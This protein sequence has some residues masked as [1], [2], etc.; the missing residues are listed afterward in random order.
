MNK[1]C[2]AYLQI[3]LLVSFS[4]SLSYLIHQTDISAN[5][6]YEIE[7]Y[8]LEKDVGKIL[9]F[10]GRILFSKVFVSALEEQDLLDGPA[11]CLLTKEGAYCQQYPSSEC[12]ELCTSAC[13]QAPL[14][15]VNECH[16]TC[17]D[18]N[19]GSCAPN[20]PRISCTTGQWFNS[21]VENVQQCKIGC[22]VLGSRARLMTQQQC[23]YTLSALGRQ[24]NYRPDV[25]TVESCNALA[26]SI[27]EGACVIELNEEKRCKFT[28]KSDCDNVI[29]GD[30]YEGTL[31]SNP[32]LNTTCERQKTTGCVQ[33]KDEV[34]WLDSC[35][36]RENIY[37]RDKARSF[38][39]GFV[40]AKSE[41]CQLGTSLNPFSNKARCGNCD[42][43][44]GSICGRAS[45]PGE[46]AFGSYVCK[47]LGC[48]DENGKRREHLESW[49]QYQGSIGVD[50]SKNRATDTPG[51][52]HFRNTCVRGEIEQ[53]ACADFRNEICVESKTNIGGGRQF[54]TAACR[55]NQWQSCV[56]YNTESDEG[57]RLSQCNANPDCFVKKVNV[58]S[59]FRFDLC[60][61]KYPPGFNLE[62]NGR[63]EGA[64]LLCS[65]ASLSCTKIM[66]KKI[67]GWK[68]KANC[69]CDSAQFTQQV[70]DLC[71]SLGDCGAS[72]NYLGMNG[73]GYRVSGA[74]G[75]SAG[76][77]A[78]LSS[79]SN[80]VPGKVASPG[81]IGY[82]TG[83]LGIPPGV[84]SAE[85]ADSV[86]GILGGAQQASLLLALPDLAIGGAIYIG[87]LQASAVSPGV[88]AGAGALV[89][90]S[91]GL[92]VT[93]LLIDKLG[94]GPGLSSGVI[95]TLL[96]AGAIGGALVGYAVSSQILLAG[97]VI[98]SALPGAAALGPV[99]WII[100]A[101][102]LIAIALL[103]IF[104]IGKV[105]K[106]QVSFQC[107][108]WQPPLGGSQ[109]D[110]CGSDGLPCSKYA[111]QSLGQTCTIINENTE[112]ASCID[113]SPD[114]VAS[115]TIKPLEGVITD[116]H[117]YTNIQD[118]GFNIEGPG[119][120]V[121]A[122]TNLIFG[123]SLD[124][125][126]QCAADI[127]PTLSY[128]EMELQLG[129]SSLFRKNHTV[130]LPVPSLAELGLEEYDPGTNGSY[131]L[132]VR[133][134]DKKGNV[135][136]QE[137]KINFCIGKGIDVTP[138][139][140]T[141]RIPPQDTVSWNATSQF[142][143]I[144]VNE[145]A[146]CH[147]DVANKVYEQ[148]ANNL[149]CYTD[150][151]DREPF[152]WRCEDTFPVG[153]ST[154]NFYVRC[155]DQPWLMNDTV[156]SDI[157]FNSTD[158]KTYQ[159]NSNSESYTFS[160]QRSS[161]PLIISSISPNS[162]I[163]FGATP[164]AIALDVRT[165]GGVDGKADCSYKLNRNGEPIGGD[166]FVPP[167][168]QIHQANL[169][170]IEGQYELDISCK[171]KAEN[172]AEKRARFEVL[173]DTKA[174]M[175]TRV[176]KNGG[177]FRVITDE[178]ATCA[179]LLENE[180]VNVF[181]N[182]TDL[183]GAGSRIHELAFEHDTTYFIGCKDQF[184]NNQGSLCSAIIKSG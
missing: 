92:A 168:R 86:S 75:L 25:T 40:L 22:C 16:G 47:D 88:A 73:D 83:L 155:K 69:E 48:V 170:L 177:M 166:S 134:R 107:N 144:Y 181:S 59:N 84:G 118:N 128:D 79:Y 37:D 165:S 46:A 104:G 82:Y 116:L 31:C 129:A 137:Y 35:G 5:A 77:L 146:E 110:K 93:G 95:Y 123:V 171:D 150:L 131:N 28:T 50:E 56:Y 64:E 72:V 108:P 91:I 172:S 54:S 178:S 68:C 101:V 7:D 163:E 9:E 175:V 125:P 43:T 99:G 80:V 87:A 145:P 94:I 140:I 147:W 138:P 41:S 39:N 21:P 71:M 63:G 132:F 98:Q 109:C 162:T 167:D 19:Y 97:G 133:C 157:P 153:A 44:G 183:S 76:Y 23:A 117:R 65:L 36:N 11:T 52:R 33:E 122:Y 18:T 142:T 6:V 34:Y 182:G 158:N 38:N 60:A 42:Y 10:F 13:I 112:E 102:V 126:G 151:E 20:A 30:F 24:L 90:A 159:R 2:I 12:E 70:N 27:I 14:S 154:N 143:K 184:N 136:A 120:C 100:I 96:T 32:S 49:C 152:G 141:I 111:C 57:R 160:L 114:D 148:M 58:G 124:E 149:A 67:G 121:D 85:L 135:N 115:P 89:G 173:L 51:S 139:Q 130:F 55:L 15:T 169:R 61:P 45:N 17:F 156:I 103:K 180:C 164:A 105:K 119:G 26:T 8:S 113:S 29:R 78:G 4:F 127:R 1:E 81:A 174:P 3:V 66:V 74:P 179:Y 62:P 161:S 176:Y 53:D 106:I